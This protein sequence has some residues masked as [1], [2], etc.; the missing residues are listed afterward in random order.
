MT[1][2]EWTTMRSPARRLLLG[3]IRISRRSYRIPPQQQVCILLYIPPFIE[4]LMLSLGDDDFDDFIAAPHSAGPTTSTQQFTALPAAP[5]LTPAIQPA[6]QPAKA[7]SPPPVQQPGSNLFDMLNRTTSSGAMTAARPPMPTMTPTSPM[8]PTP[9]SPASRTTTSSSI[10]SPTTGIG[11]F[12]AAGA[13]MA[14]A[15]QHKKTGSS[16]NFD[17][18]WS[19]SLGGSKPAAS[20]PAAAPK[21]IKDLEKEKAQAGIWGGAQAQNRPPASAGFGSFT[22][23]SSSSAAAPPP[24]SSSNGG[25]I[26][27]LLF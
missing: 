19:M 23:A 17:D 8:L 25:G 22:G 20:T 21:S 6:L 7:V 16:A 14:G 2:L 27:D 18:L 13:G 24:S 11:A 9:L 12:G 5:V 4:L 3:R 15:A 1:C 26:D 10:T